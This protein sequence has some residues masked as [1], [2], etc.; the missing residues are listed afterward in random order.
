MEI[1]KNKKNKELARSRDKGERESKER[2]KNGGNGGVL[3]NSEH[4]C[5]NQ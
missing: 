4:L 5:P 3:Q 2:L 1:K